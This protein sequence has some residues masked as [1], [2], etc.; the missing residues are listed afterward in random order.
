MRRYSMRLIR[1]FPRIAA[2]LALTL[3]AALHAET[4]NYRFVDVALFPQA[5]VEANDQEVDGEG[6]QLR[7]SLPLHETFF[8][9]TELQLLN[10]D[11]S[12]D[13]TRLAIGGG[14]HWALGSQVDFVARGGI[15]N[16]QI[17][18]GPQNDDDT[19]LFVG[20]RIRAIVAPRLEVEGG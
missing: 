7:G 9:F 1:S 13:S 11:H 15:V 6:I 14:G 18:Y 12:V 2:V 10:L 19:S 8:V 3:P 5:E 17:D 16:L 4:F 20:A